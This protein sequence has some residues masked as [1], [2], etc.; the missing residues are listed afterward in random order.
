[1]R[2]D[3][4][5]IP[6][7]NFIWFNSH[8]K[9]N[10]VP[11]TGSTVV[12][13]TNSTIVINGMPQPGPNA[14]ITFSP[15]YSC[16]TTTYD[17]ASGTFMTTAPT[18]GSDEIWLT[19]LSFPEPPGFNFANAA[20]TWNGTFSTNTS[21]VT[22]QWQWG[23]AVYTSPCFTTNYTAIAPLAGHGN[24]CI[25]NSGGD[26]AGT[27]EGYSPTTGQLLKKCVIGGAR[28]GGGSNWTGSWSGTANVTPV[29]QQ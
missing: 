1:V 7:G 16:L 29:C 8:F 4:A 5:S 11:T 24:S 19:G 27:P 20:V 22:M 13:F 9:A 23:A 2:I 18:G 6:S 17:S 10:G 15:S 26:H 21:G 14:T 28:G 3:N 12:T 25:G